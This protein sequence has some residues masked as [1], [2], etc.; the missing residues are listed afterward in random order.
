MVEKANDDS[1]HAMS[2]SIS[3]GTRNWADLVPKT[4]PL[5]YRILYPIR[6]RKLNKSTY[7]V[8]IPEDPL[9][10]HIQHR[11]VQAE[12]LTGASQKYGSS[13]RQQILQETADSANST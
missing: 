4:L 2:F 13:K 10:P 12:V 7:R 1:T 5:L 8:T 9:W 6:H 11:D 3:Y